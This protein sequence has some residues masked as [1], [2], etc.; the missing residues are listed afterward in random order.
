MIFD[1]NG[2]IPNFVFDNQWLTHQ[3]TGLKVALHGDTSYH[4]LREAITELK[5]ITS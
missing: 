3:P 1:K 5:K 4:N 2:K